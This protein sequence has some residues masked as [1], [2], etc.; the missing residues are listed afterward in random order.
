MEGFNPVNGAAEE[1][2]RIRGALGEILQ[3]KQFEHLSA[4]SE[5]HNAFD[6]LGEALKNFL[7]LPWVKHTLEFLASVWSRVLAFLK[8]LFG[9]L[10]AGE[11]PFYLFVFMVIVLMVLLILHIY[12]NL[13]KNVVT[14]IREEEKESLPLPVPRADFEKRARERE[15]SGEYLMAMAEMFHSFLY[16]LQRKGIAGIGPSLTVRELGMLLEREGTLG[17]RESLQALLLSYEKSFY[18][19]GA[20]DREAFLGFKDLY[21]GLKREL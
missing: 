18:G 15:A 3:Q 8:L 5:S 12:R 17:R 14:E 20:P 9:P 2:D 13:K 11:R 7:A 21:E 10:A 6:Y 19:K 4:P 16:I 1:S